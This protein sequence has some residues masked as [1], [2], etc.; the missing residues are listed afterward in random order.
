MHGQNLTKK[1]QNS[2]DNLMDFDKLILIV[3][4]VRKEKSREKKPMNSE[5]ILTLEKESMKFIKPYLEDLKNVTCAREIK[6][7]LKFEVK[8]Y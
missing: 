2:P 4:N 5:I 3:D 8:F 1:K 6:E 7:G